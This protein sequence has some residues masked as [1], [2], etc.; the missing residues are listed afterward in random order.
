[1][2]I[3]PRARYARKQYQERRRATLAHILL[4]LSSEPLPFEVR[5]MTL[6]SAFY[7][8]PHPDLPARRILLCSAQIYQLMVEEGPDMMS[9]H[10]MNHR[11]PFHFASSAFQRVAGINPRGICGCALTEIIAVEDHGIVKDTLLNVSQI[12]SNRLGNNIPPGNHGSNLW[13]SRVFFVEKI[14]FSWVIEV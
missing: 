6:I 13:V 9:I 3:A 2:R 4:V 11:A 12:H 5:S 8:H 1:M 14:R 10:G 7:P